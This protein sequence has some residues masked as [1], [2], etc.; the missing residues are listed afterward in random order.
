MYANPE[1]EAYVRVATG[2]HYTVRD[3]QQFMHG[4]GYEVGKHDGQFGPKTKR[5][6]VSYLRGVHPNAHNTRERAIDNKHP[7]TGQFQKGGSRGSK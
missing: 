6:L 2:D 1:Q 3:A 7:K 5:A 4:A